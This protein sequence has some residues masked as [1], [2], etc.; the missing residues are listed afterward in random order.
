M[1]ENGKG[2]LFGRVIKSTALV[3]G[4]ILLCKSL[5]F[6][7]KVLLGSIYGSKEQKYQMD[8]Y[9]AMVTIAVLFYDIVRYSLIPALLPAV[10]EEREKRG[11]KAAWELASSFLNVILP[12]LAIAVIAVIIFPEGVLGL[13]FP[14]LP[15]GDAEQ[16]TKMRLAINL[17][18]IMFAGGFFL[19]AGGIAYA[20][21]NSYKRFVAPALGDFTFKAVGMV[22]LVAIALFLNRLRPDFVMSSGIKMVSWGIMLGCVGLLGVQLLALRKKLRFYRLAVNIKTPASRRVLVSA[23]P[24]LIYA[25]FYFGRRIMDIFFAFQTA[26]G[27]YS[28]LD[29]SYRLIEFPFRLVVEPLGY[30]LFPFLAALAVKRSVSPLPRGREDELVDVLMVALR[31]LVLI[32]LP[33]SIGLFLLRQPAV[34]ALFKYGRFGNVELTI[35]PLKWYSLGIVAFGVDIILMRAYFAVKDVVTPVALEVLAFFTNLV[36]ILV[37]R[38]SMQS[39]GIALAFTI[40]R[41]AKAILLFAFLKYRF[42]TIRWRRNALFLSKVV[43]AA[44]AMGIVVYLMREFLG[45]Q[46]DPDNKVARFAMLLAPAVTGGVAYAASIFL[47]RVK[48]VRD[49][50][51]MIRPKREAV[52]EK[53]GPLR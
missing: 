43:P 42:G 40:A 29:F 13:L 11:E 26:E 9:L 38:G 31:G 35:A 3:S 12:V 50:V 30:V 39:A 4:I 53:K 51:A 25:V 16:E 44:A 32:L 21:L 5:G 20:M 36:L 7:E 19:I 10:C 48:D 45:N 49:L 52:Q 6:L 46:L 47:L 33:L 18:R 8:I 14:R 17:L 22:P 41:T 34:V 2:G 28:G 37:L 23:A 15:G 1:S 27:A 24:L